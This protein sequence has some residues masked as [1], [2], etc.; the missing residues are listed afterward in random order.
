MNLNHIRS[1]KNLVMLA[2]LISGSINS[3]D[4]N[5][6]ENISDVIEL[7]VFHFDT[8]LLITRYIT[9]RLKLFTAILS[10]FLNLYFHFEV[11]RFW[12]GMTTYH[13]VYR[14]IRCYIESS[15]P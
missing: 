11:K 14:K 8:L 15:N 1:C 7:T 12:P 4:K 9:V 13:S 10:M 5:N 2:T 6:W 3:I